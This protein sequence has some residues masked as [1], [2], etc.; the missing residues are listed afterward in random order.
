M[1]TNII[2]KQCHGTHH[3]SLS[4][5]RT[6]AQVEPST[7]PIHP[8]THART[9]QHIAFRVSWRR[10][11]IVKIPRQHMQSIYLDRHGVYSMES[12]NEQTNE[13]KCAAELLACR[14]KWR[15]ITCCDSLTFAI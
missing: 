3:T 1:A 5:H 10:R 14:Q 8:P 4:S 9:S 7:A 13:L 2:G 11:Y 6:L 12:V 15:H